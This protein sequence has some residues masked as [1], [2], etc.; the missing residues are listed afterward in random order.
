MTFTWSITR[1]NAITPTRTPK[2]TVSGIEV[3]EVITQP[4]PASVAMSIRS[5]VEN[6]ASHLLGQEL[7]RTDGSRRRDC[8]VTGVGHVG[9]K[10]CP[11]LPRSIAE[12]LMNGS[13]G[14]P[15]EAVRQPVPLI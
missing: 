4:N 1:A 5:V 10:P 14:E 15:S 3:I 6:N 9:A 7:V 8:W 2:M 12:S 13:Y 11:Y